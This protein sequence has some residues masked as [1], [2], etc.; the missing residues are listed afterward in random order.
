MHLL[1]VNRFGGRF[2][3]ALFLEPAKHALFLTGS[4][5]TR[6]HLLDPSVL[7]KQAWIE[8]YSRTFILPLEQQNLNN[9]RLFISLC[10]LKCLKIV[11]FSYWISFPGC[12]FQRA[13]FL[14]V[15]FRRG[16]FS[17]KQFSRESICEKR[18][19]EDVSLPLL[20]HMPIFWD[21]SFDFIMFHL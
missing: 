18:L 6:S 11:W 20:C 8:L 7:L 15:I 10:C 14:L 5:R 12:S 13:G 19:F 9:F 4:D 17:E 2:C 1:N 3:R 21:I 16:K